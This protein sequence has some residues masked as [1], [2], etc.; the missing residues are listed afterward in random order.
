LKS[1]RLRGVRAL[2]A[3]PL[4]LHCRTTRLLMATKPFFYL[5]VF[6]KELQFISLKL[7]LLRVISQN[8]YLSAAAPFPSLRRGGAPNNLPPDAG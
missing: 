4:T 1:G 7:Q 8:F 6:V 3:S 5:V 2:V